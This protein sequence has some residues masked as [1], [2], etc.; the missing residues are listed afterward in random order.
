MSTFGDWMW[1]AV[2]N[3][4]TGVI[5]LG[6]RAQTHGRPPAQ[7]D[8]REENTGVWKASPLHDSHLRGRDNLLVCLLQT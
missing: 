7:S 1:R 8:W 5:G 2:L 6:A 3:S 4:G